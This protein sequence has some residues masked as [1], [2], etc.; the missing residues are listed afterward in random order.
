MRPKSVSSGLVTAFLLNVAGCVTPSGSAR[1]PGTTVVE[2]SRAETP[3]WVGLGVGRMH[4]GGASGYR[5]VVERSRLR[6]L[7]VGLKETQLTALV[8]S[9]K[10]L[11][12]QGRT[13]LGSATGDTDLVKE[14]S[15]PELDRVVAEV[16]RD[17]HARK[18][19]IA[20]IYFE[21]LSNEGALGSVP[22][23]FYKAFVLVQVP[24]EALPE[25]VAQVARRLLT[26][27]D[28]RLKRLGQALQKAPLRAPDLS[29]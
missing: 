22:A 25:V 9:Q 1:D 21:K 16:S 19:K 10:A 26:S 5:F 24:I 15:S 23:E 4:G 17:V 13:A 7:P 14:G 28:A 20:D 18:A 8:E 11:A 29:H 12:A 2:K 6:D 27:S 3:A